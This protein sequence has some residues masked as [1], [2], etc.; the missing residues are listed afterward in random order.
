MAC[1][2]VGP[3]CTVMDADDPCGGMWTGCAGVAVLESPPSGVMVPSCS[4]VRRRWWGS[5]GSVLV[6]AGSVIHWR[7][8]ASSPGVILWHQNV[9]FWTAQVRG[10]SRRPLR[11]RVVRCC[12]GSTILVMGCVRGS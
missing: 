9:P 6:L 8:R 3:G 10:R 2:G 4:T 12:G 5:A 11:S 1:Q 7:R